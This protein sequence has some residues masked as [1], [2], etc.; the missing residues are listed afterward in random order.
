[1]LH[2]L[3]LICIRSIDTVEPHFGDTRSLFLNITLSVTCDLF[4]YTAH[5]CFLI[6]TVRVK[7]FCDNVDVLLLFCRDPDGLRS[8][9]YLV[10]RPQVYGF[11]SYWP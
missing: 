6:L 2:V 1:M 5:A 9:Y 3:T 7:W 8:F 10:P 4:S 11:L